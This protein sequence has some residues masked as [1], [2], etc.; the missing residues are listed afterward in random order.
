MMMIDNDDDGSGVVNDDTRK[1]EE[2]VM[3]FTHKYFL[4]HFVVVVCFACDAR[5]VSDGLFINNFP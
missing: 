2:L 3:Y 4:A 1:I 5:N